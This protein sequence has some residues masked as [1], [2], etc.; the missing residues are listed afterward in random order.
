MP[1]SNQK[2]VTE[3]YRTSVRYT[4][5]IW[6][7]HLSMM[8]GCREASYCNTGSELSSSQR[9]E[10]TKIRR[11]LRVSNVLEYLVHMYVRTRVPWYVRTDHG[12]PTIA[13]QR[14]RVLYSST[15]SPMTHVEGLLSLSRLTLNYSGSTRV[16]THVTSSTPEYRRS[17]AVLYCNIRRYQRPDGRPVALS[18][19]RREAVIGPKHWL[20]PST[21]ANRPAGHSLQLSAPSASE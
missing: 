2:V 19:R 8:R 5:T 15:Y 10:D 9:Y 3:H 16:R 11:Y 12:T 13:I 14:T 1:F 20:L 7:V 21:S 6:Y 18:A 17:P 4:C